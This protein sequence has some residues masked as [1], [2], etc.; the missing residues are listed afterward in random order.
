[1]TTTWIKQ[2]QGLFMNTS[3]PGVVVAVYPQNLLKN[4]AP[5]DSV[6][7][8]FKS[9][10]GKIAD[11]KVDAVLEWTGEGQLQRETSSQLPIAA[12]RKSKGHL[13]VRITLDDQELAD[14][15]PLGAAGSVAIYTNRGK[16]FHV[17]SKITVRV[18]MWMNYL[19][20]AT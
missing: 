5:G 4:V 15:L 3:I 17:I 6:E 13:L 19:P 7:I 20:V 1:M 2:S 14:D 9:L 12:D 8:A 16:P 11:G 18:K 10:P